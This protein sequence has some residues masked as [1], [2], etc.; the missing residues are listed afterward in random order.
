M[1]GRAR[2]TTLPLAKG[3]H[4]SA[5]F[6]SSRQEALD[7]S[8]EVGTRQLKYIGELKNG[9]E[10]GTVLAALQKAYVLGVVTAVE[11]E[12]FLREMTLLPELTQDP[13]KRSLFWRAI[14]VLGWHPQF[15]VCGLSI[16][17]ST[18]YSI[19]DGSSRFPE[20]CTNGNRKEAA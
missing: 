6:P 12:R 16:N 13:R 4:F 9:G 14:F 3:S 18:K 8:H 1:S 19:H 5:P 2:L 11:G 17:T 15:G 20:N 10:G 7:A